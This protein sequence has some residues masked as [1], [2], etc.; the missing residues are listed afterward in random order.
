MDVI[1]DQLRSV[2][3]FD[4]RYQEI[5]QYNQNNKWTKRGIAITPARFGIAWIGSH[6]SC[7]LNVYGDGSVEITHAGVEIGQGI[8]TKVAQTVAYVLGIPLNIISVGRHSSNVTPNA[9]GTGGSITS[10]LCSTAALQ[11]CTELNNRLAPIKAA[12][13]PNAAWTDIIQ[14]ALGSGVDLQVRGNVFPGTPPNS[15]IWQY[16]S[17]SACV[18]E[19]LVDVLT[20]EHQ[21]L[22]SDI[23]FDAGISL[24]PVVDIGQIEGGYVMGLGLFLTE[25]IQYDSNGSPVQYNTWEYKPLTGFDI[26]LDFRVSLLKDA[27]NPAGFLSS[28]ASGEPPLALASGALMAIQHAVANYRQAAAKDTKNYWINA[29]ASPATTQLS[30]QIAPSELTF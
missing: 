30:A 4:A 13:G 25:E 20:G 27:P 16:Q 26:P 17:Y 22:R 29:P 8:D 15:Q 3:N 19:V 18:T 1:Y 10:G 14:K 12:L 6:F 7:L 23:L 2:S 9:T 24:N 11:A 5:Q 21:L 28:K